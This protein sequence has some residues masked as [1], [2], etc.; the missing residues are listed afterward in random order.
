M[1]PNNTNNA[2]IKLIKLIMSPKK[3]G[4]FFMKKGN[5]ENRI[6]IMSDNWCTI[7]FIFILFETSRSFIYCFQNKYWLETLLYIYK[8]SWIQI[9]SIWD[10]WIH[11][12]IFEL[13]LR[14]KYDQS[15]NLKQ[16]CRE[17]FKMHANISKRSTIVESL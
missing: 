3:R 8:Y 13:D 14:N 4:L 17:S 9:K 10:D 16:A 7:N 11:H 2:S 1:H 15:S 6:D 12:N 5:V